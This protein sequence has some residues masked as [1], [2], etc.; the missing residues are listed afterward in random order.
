MKI[1]VLKDQQSLIYFKVWAE[2]DA[3]GQNETV[4]ANPGQDDTF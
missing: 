3:F 4:S 2:G 1:I